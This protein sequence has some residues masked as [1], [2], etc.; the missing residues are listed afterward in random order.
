M[1]NEDRGWHPSDDD[2]DDR[3]EPYDPTALDI[4]L[5]DTMVIPMQANFPM[6]RY[7]IQL[8]YKEPGTMEGEGR[9]GQAFQKSWAIDQI[10][11]MIYQYGGLDRWMRAECRSMVMEVMEGGFEDGLEEMRDRVMSYTGQWY[12]SDHIHPAQQMSE[13]DVPGA[14]LIMTVAAISFIGYV[15]RLV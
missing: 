10:P 11:A 7:R 14:P 5:P 12:V 1:S 13:L 2:E 4:L 9:G 3:W 15:G 8:T 6:F